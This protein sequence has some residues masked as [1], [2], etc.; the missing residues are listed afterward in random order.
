MIHSAWHRLNRLEGE[1]MKLADVLESLKGEKAKIGSGN[2]FVYCGTVGEDIWE[3]LD[4]SSQEEF[5]KAKNTYQSAQRYD[6]NFEKHFETRLKNALR[7]NMKPADTLW[8]DQ[9]SI[10]RDI[11]IITKR[12]SHE[13]DV[14]RR[15][16]DNQLK[17]LK[18][19]IDSWTSFLEREV[20]E[21]FTGIY[22]DRIIIFDGVEEGA[23]W[24]EDEYRK[25]HDNH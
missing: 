12:I 22:G 17:S 8:K 20:V 14:D 1:L 24:D 21:V 9:E 2:A 18:E 16:L 15:R 11:E 4:T 3:I 6:K 10:K 25:A 7:R 13:K 5:E 23:Y 19:R